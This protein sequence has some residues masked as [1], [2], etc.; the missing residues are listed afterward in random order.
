MPTPDLSR[1]SLEERATLALLLSKA[2]P[3]P[4]GGADDNPVRARPAPAGGQGPVNAQ[5]RRVK[6]PDQWVADQIANV[7]AVGAQRYMTGVLNPKKDPIVAGIAAQ[8]RYEAA[9]MNREVLQRRVSGLR[10]TNMQTWANMSVAV[11]AGRLAEGVELHRDKIES[12]VRG[13]A[14]A[15]EAHL[16]VIDRLP[17]VTSADRNR[18]M[19]ENVEGL[20]KM[21]GRF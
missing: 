5:V 15:L 4:A 18:K 11:G 9:M 12:F 17:N 14:P 19:I 1:L 8:P 16:Q 7:R 2:T 13:Y 6:S 10:K 20:R 21:K 3:A